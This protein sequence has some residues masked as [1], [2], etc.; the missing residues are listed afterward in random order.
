MDLSGLQDLIPDVAGWLNVEPSTLLF[1]LA[2]IGTTANIVSRLIPDDQP[3]WLGTVRRIATV[4]GLYVPNRVTSGVTVTDVAKAIVA[5]GEHE[6]VTKIQ[7]AAAQPGALIPEVVD[8][9][10]GEVEKVIPAFP[11]LV[12]IPEHKETGDDDPR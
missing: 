2:L 5:K 6:V 8:A 11:G 12:G 1:Y 10:V 7:E 3:G 4:I 9:T